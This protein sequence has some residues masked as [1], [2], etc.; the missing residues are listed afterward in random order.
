MYRNLLS[1]ALLI[2]GV[3]S[4][5]AEELKQ[6]GAAPKGHSI[7]LKTWEKGIAVESVTE[8]PVSAYLWFYE[9][10]LFDA[11]KMGDNTPGSSEWKW[12]L[13]PDGKTAEMKSEWLS[14]TARAREDG[15]DLLMKITNQATTSR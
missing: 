10:H 12:D 6:E 9:W 8:P 15:A 1:I 3:L 4:L 13:S 5:T 11:V 14:L 7:K 2:L